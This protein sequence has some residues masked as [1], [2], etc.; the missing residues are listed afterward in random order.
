VR[1]V[2]MKE[3]TAW[4]PTSDRSRLTPVKAVAIQNTKV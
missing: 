1:R 4:T 3:N 2:V